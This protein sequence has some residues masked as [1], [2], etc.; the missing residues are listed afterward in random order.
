MLGTLT[1]PGASSRRSH[2]LRRY[3]LD[4]PSLP[5][6]GTRL[7]RIRSSDRRL[8]SGWWG[9]WPGWGRS[10][11]VRTASTNAIRRTSPFGP[12]RPCSP[13]T[14]DDR[15]T[16]EGKCRPEGGTPFGPKAQPCRYPGKSRNSFDFA[17]R[18]AS[19]IRRAARSTV[20]HLSV[21]VSRDGFC[22]RI[23]AARVPLRVAVDG[24]PSRGG[25]PCA[26]DVPPGL[27]SPGATARP[28]GNGRLA[29][30]HCQ[31]PME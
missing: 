9:I 5:A 14:A 19:N 24:K 8:P 6:P 29:L 18:Q 3:R 26:G 13:N 1:R 4:G 16:A 15:R 21:R 30:Y 11:A 12:W 28:E 20:A 7:P 22:G 17:P 2:R 31:E 23:P 10:Q 25:G 27:A